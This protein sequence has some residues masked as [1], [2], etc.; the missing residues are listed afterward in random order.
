MVD[1][2]GGERQATLAAVLRVHQQFAVEVLAAD[3]QLLPKIFDLQREQLVWP[4]AL[5]SSLC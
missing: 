3:A 2:G 5:S 1:G 4:Q